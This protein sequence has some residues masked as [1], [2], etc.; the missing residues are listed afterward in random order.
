M[1]II[2][3]IPLSLIALFETQIAHARSERVR[4]YFAGAPPDEEGD[5]KIENP[6]SDDPNGEICSMT[7]D[8]LVKAFPE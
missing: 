4:M 2:F 8:E 5:P 6:E 7:F 1:S 3:F